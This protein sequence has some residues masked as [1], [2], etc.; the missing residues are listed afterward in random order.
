MF[1]AH[2]KICLRQSRFK[3]QS[4][5]AKQAA[6]QGTGKQKNPVRAGV[7]SCAC[8]SPIGGISI[9]RRLPDSEN[10]P[11]EVATPQEV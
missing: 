7:L 5:T 2:Q 9:S 8:V 4:G 3:S 10:E 1:D 11:P 6:G